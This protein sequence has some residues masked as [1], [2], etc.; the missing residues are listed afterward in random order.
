MVRLTYLSPMLVL[1]LGACASSNSASPATTGDVEGTVISTG[2]GAY[3]GDR[4]ASRTQSDRGQ[5]RNNRRNRGSNQQTNIPQ[6]GNVS[7]P[8]AFPP[9][10]HGGFR[11]ARVMHLNGVDGVI[12]ANG[13]ALVQQFGA[14]RLDVREGDVRKLQFVSDACVLDIYLYPSAPGADPTATYVDARRASDGL[15]VDRVSCI[16]MLRGY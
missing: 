2:S 3:N 6:P 1:L 15:D 5:R 8:N 13:S 7:A 9:P 4:R 14:P 10:A 16:K 11:T 12:G